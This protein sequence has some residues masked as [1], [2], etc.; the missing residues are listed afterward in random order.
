MVTVFYRPREVVVRI[1]DFG[2]GIPEEDLRKIFDPFMRGRNAESFAGSGL[3]LAIAKASAEA[4]GGTIGVSSK[5]G[6]GTTFEITFP[7]GRQAIKS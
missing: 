7:L 4:L 3:G 5:T 6:G 1:T 2:I